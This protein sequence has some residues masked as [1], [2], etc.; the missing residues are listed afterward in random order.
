M[1]LAL[2]PNKSHP[3]KSIESA[4]LAECR[5]KEYGPLELEETRS[6]C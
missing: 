5:C 1:S 3:S 4:K 6:F 2:F